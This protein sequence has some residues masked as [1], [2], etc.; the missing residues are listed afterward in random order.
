MDSFSNKYL[1]IVGTA[2]LYDMWSNFY[3]ERSD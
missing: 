1:Q 2:L 3:D